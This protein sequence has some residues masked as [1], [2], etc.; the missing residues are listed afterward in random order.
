MKVNKFLGSNIL[1]IGSI[2]V[3][4]MFVGVNHVSAQEQT[5]NQNFVIQLSDI[6]IDTSSVQ[7]DRS[8]SV[9]QRIVIAPI[10]LGDAANSIAIQDEDWFRGLFYYLVASD[11]R[12]GFTDIPFHYVVSKRGRVY[13]GNSGGEERKISIAGVGDDAVVIAYLADTKASTFDIRA[14]ES[15]GELVLRTA[16][17]HSIPLKNVTVEGVK[18]VQ[19][20]E[21]QTVRLEK[22]EVFG[23]WNKEVSEI[24]TSI[25]SRY[26]PQQK[27]YK[28]S[29]KE[30][31]LPQEEVESGTTIKGS[32]IVAN[33]GDYGIYGGT[34]T[35]II[36][37]KK[38]TGPSRFF[39]N[40]EWLSPTQLSLMKPEDVILPGEELELEFTV[41]TPLYFGEQVERFRL[42]NIAGKSLGDIE[43]PI[44]LKIARPEGTIVQIRQT[45]TGWLRLRSTPNG[46]ENNEIGRVSSG[47]RFYQVD[48]ANNGWIKIRLN[49]G[50]EG[51]VSLQ[52]VEYV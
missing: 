41:G 52:F 1:M 9:P 20:S 25:N 51:W 22:A 40:N 28:L 46:V 42:E 21:Q 48:N 33:Q 39:V 37:T 16:N 32:I 15:V 17:R 31:K 38:N 36:A 7:E 12:S 49:D 2:I 34:E 6:K 10:F 18:F 35:E 19:D 23:L 30:V 47:E 50:T 44:S 14:K 29:V 27:T 11:G 3:S 13:E 4:A 43:F 24:V 45:T 26:E 8:F 5:Q